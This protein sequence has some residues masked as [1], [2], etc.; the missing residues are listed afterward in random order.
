MRRRA[1][2]AVVTAALIAITVVTVPTAAQSAPASLPGVELV[3]DVVFPDASDA[4]LADI[5]VR[6][7][8]GT[9]AYRVTLNRGDAVLQTQRVASSGGVAV[10]EAESLAEGRYVVSVTRG[11]AS[12]ALQVMIRRGWAPIHADQPSWARCRTIK[13]SYDSGR[14]PANG[15]RYML[16]DVN[17]VLSTLKT[18]TGLQFTRVSS[19]G[20][21]A[22][23]WGDTGGA[24]GVG[25]VEWT[26]GP[27]TVTRGT[28]TLSPSSSWARTPGPAERQVLLLHETAH[29]IGLGHVTNSRSLMSPTYR[30]GLTRA[31]LGAGELRALRTIYRPT[32]CG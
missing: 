25:G 31:A 14:A 21:L 32:S 30:P 16:R 8:S 20:V 13:W 18:A 5:R 7:S 9:T 6:V 26:N 24:D 2:T 17:A 3:H 23:K 22:Y 12:V 10:L 28:V 1:L 15:D 29:A 4:G 19:G 27:G 11:A